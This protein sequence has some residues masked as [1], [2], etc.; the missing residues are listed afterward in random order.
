MKIELR[1]EKISAKKSRKG[2][3]KTS[4][5]TNGMNEETTLF[6]GNSSS[7][8]SDGSFDAEEFQ[9]AVQDLSFE[10]LDMQDTLPPMDPPV[11]PAPESKLPHSNKAKCGSFSKATKRAL[12][13]LF[14]NS[15]TKNRSKTT[16]NCDDFPDVPDHPIFEY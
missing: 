8:E 6:S 15:E 2:V 9:R 11:F 4:W 3:R 12:S 13:Q 7:S 14:K 10:L 16:I 1:M 5:T